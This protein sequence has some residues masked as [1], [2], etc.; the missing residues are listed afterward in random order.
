MRSPTAVIQASENGAWPP[1]CRHGWKWSLTV[2][3]SMPCSSAATASSTS[4]R[5]A[6]CSADALYPSFSA[7][8]ATCSFLL[9]LHTTRGHGTSSRRAITDS[10]HFAQT[11]LV[12][13]TLVTDGD[14]ASCSSTPGFPGSR[15]DVLASI[16]PARV[17][18][19]RPARD[20]AD[21]R[22]HRPLRLGDLVR[23]NPW[24][25]GVLPRRRGRPRQARIPRA[26]VAGRHR[27]RSLAAALAE[28]VGG[29]QPARAR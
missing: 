2:A 20:P 24:H 12:N 1:S 28:V 3:L 22:P 19:R 23:E 18:H 26:G 27:H 25:T 14:A 10:V 9:H 16:A 6:N 8:S 4:S 7:S 21:P 13:W 5:G 29:D 17:R 15:D 11:D